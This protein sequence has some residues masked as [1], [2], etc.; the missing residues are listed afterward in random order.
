MVF[1]EYLFINGENV[2]IALRI[3]TDNTLGFAIVMLTSMN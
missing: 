1:I 3:A 2:Y